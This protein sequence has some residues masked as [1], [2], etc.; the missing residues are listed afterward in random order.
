MACVSTL[1]NPSTSQPVI[2]HP[3]PPTPCTKHVNGRR[4]ARAVAP[5]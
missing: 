3:P 2:R 1:R 5:Q 4:P